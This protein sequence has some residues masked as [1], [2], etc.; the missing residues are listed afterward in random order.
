MITALSLLEREEETLL[1]F[2]FSI[3]AVV[4]FRAVFVVF[5]RKKNSEEEEEKRRKKSTKKHEKGG[6]E[7]AVNGKRKDT[8]R[9]STRFFEQRFVA[10]TDGENS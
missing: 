1:P 6:R 9:D 10:F 5:W 8:K 7:K 3:R 4:F 2:S